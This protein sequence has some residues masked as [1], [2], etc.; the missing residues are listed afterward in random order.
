MLLEDSISFLRKD[1][2]FVHEFIYIEE[3]SQFR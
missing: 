3:D 1:L 2:F